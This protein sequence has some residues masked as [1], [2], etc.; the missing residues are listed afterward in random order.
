MQILVFLVIG[1]LVG[2]LFVPTLVSERPDQQQPPQRSQQVREP[3]IRYSVTGEEFVVEGKEK[4]ILSGA[5][6]YFR[7]VPDYW[8]DRLKKL[9]AAGLNTVET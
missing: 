1:F 8:E 2:Y 6:H 3:A 9:K 7:V 4:R 5:I